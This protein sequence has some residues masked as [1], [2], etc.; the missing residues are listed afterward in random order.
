MDNLTHALVGVAL[1][2][3]GFKNRV[4]Y[5]T[6]ALVIAANLPD[7]DFIFGWNSVEYLAHHRGLT[8]S[9]VAWPVWT[10]LVA[11]GLRWAARQRQR[12]AAHARP[13]PHAAL[14]STPVAAGPSVRSLPVDDLAE[15]AASTRAASGGEASSGRKTPPVPGWG[16]CLLLGGLG[17]GSHLL[18]DLTNSF[19][20]RLFAPFSQHWFALDIEPI[21]DPWIWVLLLFLL[22]APMVLGLVGGEIGA[23][24]KPHRISAVVALALLCGWWGWRASNHARVLGWLNTQIFS[25]EAPLHLAAF[26]ETGT[27][28][29][30]RAV[31]DLPDR[32]QLATVDS[33][34]PHIAGIAPQ[35][36][37]KPAPSPEIRLA[38]STQA[39]Q[40]FLR[41]AR[42]PLAITSRRED[43][44]ATVL[45]TD[46]RYKFAGAA[47]GMGVVVEEDRRL[48]V[49][50]ARLVWRDASAALPG[51]EVGP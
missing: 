3:L 9:L 4:P 29:L 23:R 17:V 43:G 46:L 32:Y 15:R 7:V 50:S 41:F 44:G 26:P 40:V 39:G 16:I 10:I 13:R 1:S 47:P 11:I 38:E 49:L 51:T 8:H 22:L 37:Y 42:F 31:I 21:V 12:R 36:M 34:G 25:N 45:L 2:R 28:Q 20:V 27:P 35:V 6:T 14:A 30:W 48:H 18:L 24:K 5:A 33:G 19:G